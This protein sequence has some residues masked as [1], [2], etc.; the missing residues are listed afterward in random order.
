[1]VLERRQQDRKRLDRLHIRPEIFW[2]THNQIE[3][4]I[5]LKDE[6]CGFASDRDLDKILDVGDADSVSGK[7]LTI[8]LDGQ[9][10]KTETCSV[11]TSA[12]PCTVWR[13]D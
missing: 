6:T 3:A 7:R 2:K 12:A 5:A 11:F 10:R 9:N 1:L 4:T 8:E 13:T